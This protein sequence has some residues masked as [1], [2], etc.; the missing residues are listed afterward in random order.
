MMQVKLPL[1][2]GT[3]VKC[4]W[5][6]HDDEYHTVKVRAQRLEVVIVSG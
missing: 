2:L 1:D 3:R 4:K 5:L 6:T